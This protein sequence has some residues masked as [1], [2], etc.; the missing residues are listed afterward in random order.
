MSEIQLMHFSTPNGY[1]NSLVIGT[2][3]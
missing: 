2:H 3:K 1:S